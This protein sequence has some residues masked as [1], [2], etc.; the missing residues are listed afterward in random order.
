MRIL[1]FCVKEG[2]VNG[3]AYYTKRLTLTLETEV[4]VLSPTNG[5]ILFS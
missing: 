4:H 2:E 1:T 3:K 5:Q